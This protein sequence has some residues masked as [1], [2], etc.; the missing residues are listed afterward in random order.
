MTKA[1]NKNAKMVFRF[2]VSLIKN[3]ILHG[4]YPEQSEG[5][6]MTASCHSE[7]AY[8]GEESGFKPGHNRP[9]EKGDI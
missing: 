9:D 8:A 7:S 3:E 1:I 6:K 2:I 4:V 5:F